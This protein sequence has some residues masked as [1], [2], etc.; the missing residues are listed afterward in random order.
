MKRKAARGGKR[1]PESK[2]AGVK[3]EKSS[4]E[5]KSISASVHLGQTDTIQS[6]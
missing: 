6:R 5:A 2:G 4:V 1:D 3:Q